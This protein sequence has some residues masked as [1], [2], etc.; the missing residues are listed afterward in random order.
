MIR[1][2]VIGPGAVA[3][4]FADAMRQV[5][6]GEIVAVASRSQERAD[7]FGDRHGIPRRY[8]GEAALAADPDVDVIYVATPQSRHAADTVACL[9]AGKHVLCEKPFAINAA[10]A[11]RMVAAAR[12]RGLFLMEALW[13]RFLPAYRSLVDVVSSGRIGEVVLVEA[14]LGFQLPA[15]GEHRLNR[16]DLGGGGLLDFGIYPLQLCS[17]LLGAPERVAADGVVGPGGVDEI[18]A[19]VLRHADGGIGVVKAAIRANMGCTARIS[20]TAGLI[21]IPALMHCP[22]AFTV[23]APDGPDEVDGSYEGNGMRFEIEEVHRCLAAGLVESPT[24]PLEETLALA[25]TLDAIRDQIGLR[26]PGE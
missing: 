14:D 6:G 26:F 18:V 2:G 17:L 13:S 4:G 3:S 16:A 11:Q 5:E 20:G 23:A 10:Q 15:D 21:E 1:W 24:V 25:A 12:A 7:A 8:R 19:A 9:E 22:T